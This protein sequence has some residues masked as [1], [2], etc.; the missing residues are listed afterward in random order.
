MF[1]RARVGIW[2]LIFRR[3]ER[4]SAV[5][6]NAGQVKY[7][8]WHETLEMH[9]LVAFQTGQLVSFKK[10]LPTLQD[11]GLR[12]L[13]AEAVAALENNLRELLAY[14][15]KAPV[16][17]RDEGDVEIPGAESAQLLGVLKTAVRNYAIAITETATPELRATFVKHLTAAIALHAKVFYYMLE[18]G[19]YPSY[20]LD[21]LLATDVKNAHAALSL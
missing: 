17:N 18:R 2:Y 15:P 21:Q 5:N 14:Y 12:A 20:N 1:R 3:K 11:A 6:L 19:F 7:L 4:E 9:E 13:Y 16:L 8:A 10:K